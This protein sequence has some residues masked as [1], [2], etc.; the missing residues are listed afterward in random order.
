MA[1]Q[2]DARNGLK[3]GPRNLKQAK[4]T[5]RNASSTEDATSSRAHVDSR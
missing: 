3:N 2:V 1:S 5:R 4:G